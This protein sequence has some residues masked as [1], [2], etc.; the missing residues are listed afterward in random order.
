MASEIDEQISE[1]DRFRYSAGFMIQNEGPRLVERLVRD[2]TKT[3]F[4]VRE[5]RFPFVDL[6][7][8]NRREAEGILREREWTFHNYPGLEV[9]TV[10]AKIFDT[11]ILFSASDA[12]G[13][14]QDSL[15]RIG[16]DV[17]STGDLDFDTIAALEESPSEFLDAY[18]SDLEDFVNINHDG[19]EALLKRVRILPP[20]NVDTIEI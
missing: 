17:R 19:K 20:R 10:A 8:L 15:N 18:V 3:R 12:F 11:H 6:E 4:G 1:I 13:V 7:S 14:A 16:R 9:G 2:G 5:S